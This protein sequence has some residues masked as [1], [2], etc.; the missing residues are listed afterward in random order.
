MMLV[1]WQIGGWTIHEGNLI[2]RPDFF[3][4]SD[5]LAV[6]VDGCFWHGCPKCGHL[7]SRNALYWKTKIHQNMKRDKSI[8]RQLKRI[9]IES[10]RIWE[11]ELKVSA[12]Y[13]K[14]KLLGALSRR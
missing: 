7:P 10:L 1:R 2:G 14:S 11:H 4:P 12:A 8:K 5:K 9:G 6:F 13:V 3:F